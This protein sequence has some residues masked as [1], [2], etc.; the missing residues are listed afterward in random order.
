MEIPAWTT[1]LPRFMPTFLCDR[2]VVNL[3]DKPDPLNVAQTGFKFAIAAEFIRQLRS[4]AFED[5][6]FTNVIEVCHSFG[7]V[8]MQAVT[9][10][11]PA[12]LDAEMLP[13]LLYIRQ[14]C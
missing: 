5:T 9:A 13:V 11:N 10:Q 1:Q 12:L 14:A 3:S 4:S 6:K 8:V 2:L 7:S